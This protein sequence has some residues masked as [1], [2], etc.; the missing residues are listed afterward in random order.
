[1]CITLPP[2]ELWSPE[3]VCVS[4][5]GQNT[6]IKRLFWPTASA[7]SVRKPISGE[8]TDGAH[9]LSV[10][11]PYGHHHND[12]MHTHTHYD[13]YIQ[14]GFLLFKYDFYYLFKSVLF[15]FLIFILV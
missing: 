11:P 9:T 6:P 8:I 1:M 3:W 13:L 4:Q 12:L 14:I 15:I 5:P 10:H 2:N 7:I